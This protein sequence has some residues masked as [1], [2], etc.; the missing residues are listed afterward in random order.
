MSFWNEDTHNKLKN[1]PSYITTIWNNNKSAFAVDMTRDPVTWAVVPNSPFN[2]QPEIHRK[3][4]FCTAT[5]FDQVGYGSDLT[6]AWSLSE[7]LHVPAIS[8]GQ[9]VKL[10]F[11]FFKLLEPTVANN[12]PNNPHQTFNPNLPVVTALGW[13]G[14]AQAVGNHAQMQIRTPGQPDMLCDPTCGLVACGISYRGLVK[15]QTIPANAI[16]EIWT[17][18]NGPRQQAAGSGGFLNQLKTSLMQGT[19]QPDD[20]L[21]FTSGL[22]HFTRWGSVSYCTPHSLNVGHVYPS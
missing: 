1:N 19:Y 22:D 9:Y 2:Q 12:F 20:L 4:A 7:L 14:N 11:E 16:W 18:F 8:C 21:Y 6:N 15:N 13:E 5:A 17:R 3:L 10:A